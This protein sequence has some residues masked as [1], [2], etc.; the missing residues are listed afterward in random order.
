MSVFA[1]MGVVDVAG[2][3]LSNARLTGIVKSDSL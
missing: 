3:I 1:L 2:F